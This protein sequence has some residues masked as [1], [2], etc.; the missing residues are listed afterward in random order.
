M[1]QT[2]GTGRRSMRSNRRVDRT[3]LVDDVRFGGEVGE[4]ADVGADDEAALLGRDDDEAADGL[5]AR[6]LLHLGDDLRQLLERTAPERV[7]VFALAIELGPADAPLI[8]GE[9][10]VLEVGQRT[11]QRP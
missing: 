4:L 9:T 7:L 1:A 3:Q 5:V 8:D 2:T 11:R 10:P 6:A